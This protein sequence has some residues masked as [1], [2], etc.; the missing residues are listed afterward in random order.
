MHIRDPI[1]GV[2]EVT[3]DERALIDS[4]QYQRLRNVKQ[5]GF[6]DL[7]FPGATHT[8]YSHGLGAMSVATRV[9]DA[10]ANKVELDAD[11]RARFRQT[12]RLAVLFH[13][14]GHAP[15]SHATERIM[16]PA[17]MLALPDWVQSPHRARAGRQA[18]HED[19]TL[20]LL[21]DSGLTAEIE[22]RFAPRG[23]SPM[24]VAALVAG[25]APPGAAPFRSGGRD[26]LPILR[27]V[28]S[29][30][31]D[32]DRMD[33]LQRDSFFTGVS[34]GKFDAPWIVE[35]LT[36]VEKDGAVHLALFP[37]AVFAFEDFLLSRYHMFMSVY[38]HYA[39]VGYE[40][41]L[42]RYC[43]TSDGEY[44]LPSDIDAY[45][46]HDDVT[47]IAALRASSNPWAKRIVR[48]QGF[49]LLV[50][51]GPFEAARTADAS[52]VSAM[53][54]RLDDEGID[55][56]IT[57]SRGVLSTYGRAATLWVKSPHGDVPI[58]DYTPL[59]ARYAEPA[60]LA[61][62]YVVPERAEEARQLLGLSTPIKG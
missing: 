52:H 43:E 17:S 50:E 11:D 9:F 34:Y 10:L 26:L 60:T 1:H 21:L 25:R 39:S 2:I 44:S 41:L 58:A 40:Q 57:S 46:E 37:R 62:L 15:L 3:P 35:N 5:L 28:V 61:R 30:E 45:L 29:G 4:P 16:P 36:A 55:C 47:L 12:L 18:D 8:R 7:A 51:E 32:A 20:K 48:R 27:Q 23:I 49:K 13:D 24:H 53:S 59:Y 33:Y 6:A 22:K 56:F 14:L 31:L 42:Q 54:K 19:Y 38:F